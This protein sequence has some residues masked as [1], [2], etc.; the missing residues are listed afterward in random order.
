MKQTAII[1]VQADK[2]NWIGNQMPTERELQAFANLMRL[3]KESS[4]SCKQNNNR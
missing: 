1:P 4:K 3:I 2:I